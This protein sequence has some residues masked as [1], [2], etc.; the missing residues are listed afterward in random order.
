M[1]QCTITVT[2]LAHIVS[3][4]FA[5]STELNN[6]NLNYPR[7]R[8]EGHEHIQYVEYKDIILRAIAN[9]TDNGSNQEHSVTLGKH[10]QSVAAGK[11]ARQGKKTGDERK[12]CLSR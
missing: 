3:F 12:A 9:I 7:Y 10:K 4:N 5:A 6:Q 11:S 1:F 2:L 8:T